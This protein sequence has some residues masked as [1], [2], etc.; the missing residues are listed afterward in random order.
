MTNPFMV[1]ASKASPLP[2][3]GSIANYPRGENPEK[4]YKFRVTKRGYKPIVVN[5]YSVIGPEG[6]EPST[7][8]L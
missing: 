6:L 7:K 3:M 1:W 2:R 4:G 5:H 8:G